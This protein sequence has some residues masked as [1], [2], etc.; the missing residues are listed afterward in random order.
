MFLPLGLL[1]FAIVSVSNSE[2]N[3]SWSWAKVDFRTA[4]HLQFG[5][6]FSSD[7]N[8]TMVS[9]WFKLLLYNKIL[10]GI[11]TE[12]KQNLNCS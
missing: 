10:T 3:I 7:R 8:L 1:N 9:L 4:V 11:A 6:S 2:A 5:S 12:L